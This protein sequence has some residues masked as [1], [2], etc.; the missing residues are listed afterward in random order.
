MDRLEAAAR[1]DVAAFA[2]RVARLDPAAPMPVRGGRLWAVLPFGVL[3]CRELSGDLPEGVYQAVELSEGRATAHPAGWHGRLP[4]E[5]WNAVE[6]VPAAEI[7]R[8]DR[9]A[10]E[11]IRQRRGKSVGDRRLRDAMLDHV[12]L[13]VEYEGEVYGVQFRLIAALMRMGFLA[14]DPVRVMLARRRIGLAATFGAVWERDR[15]LP[16]L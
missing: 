4:S 7:A 14:E 16:I 3:A 5:P 8:L 13:H 2:A 1:Q 6:T 11:A 15:G 12:A 9:Q 10:A